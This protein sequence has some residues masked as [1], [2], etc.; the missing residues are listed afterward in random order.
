MKTIIQYYVVK[1]IMSDK[2]H[3]ENSQNIQ[4]IYNEKL[5]L[6]GISDSQKFLS[7]TSTHYKRVALA[8]KIGHPIEK[9]NKLTAFFDFM[10]VEGMKAV[11]AEVLVKDSVKWVQDLRKKDWGILYTDLIHHYPYITRY[12]NPEY[13]G[14]LIQNSNKTPLFI[15]DFWYESFTVMSKWYATSITS[16]EKQYSYLE[17][18]SKNEFITLMIQ[19]VIFWL[20]SIV[21]PYF[22]VFIPILF[23]FHFYRN[24]F[25]ISELHYTI[26]EKL[27]HYIFENKKWTDTWTWFLQED[28]NFF[29][30]TLCL[31]LIS[32]LGIIF[33]Q[34]LLTWNIEK[35]IAWVFSTSTESTQ[36]LEH[37][38]Y[39]S[40]SVYKSFDQE[41]IS[42]EELVWILL[43]NQNISW[44][45][46]AQN[47]FKDISESNYKEQICFAKRKWYIQWDAQNNFNP[48]AT[49]SHAA[50]LKFILNF[51]WET[52][53]WRAA[54]VTFDDLEKQ[55]WYTTYAEYAKINGLIDQ[56]EK[57]FYPDWAI[58]IKQVDSY[59][60]KL[61]QKK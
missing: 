36:K 11:V 60:Y 18:E 51:N 22:L 54:Y 8:K 44:G 17:N 37:P 31:W 41:E 4:K 23:V 57:L 46:G 28:F 55:F 52:V 10:R 16:V 38:W 48:S 27:E 45:T 26:R 43:S 15:F 40:D 5:L 32:L 53:P 19:C 42:R 59:I 50:W 6:L 13:L 25:F 56:W 39:L 34:W 30:K 9:I 2:L 12:I 14:E 29:K 58:T 21:S 3:T 35:S 1:R 20:L 24:S 47:C 7:I 33:L 49:V 61:V